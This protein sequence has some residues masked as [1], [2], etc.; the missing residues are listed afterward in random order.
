MANDGTDLGV[1]LDGI[2]DL[3]VEKDPVG[4]DYD[5]CEDVGVVL[6]QSDKLVRQPGDGV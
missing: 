3:P 2:S 5:G 6:F 4:D 1:L